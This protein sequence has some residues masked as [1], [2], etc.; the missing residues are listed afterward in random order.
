VLELGALA[1]ASGGLH[2]DGLADAADGL[3]PMLPRERRLEVMRSPTIGAFGAA[4]L[5]LV[6]LLEYAA[7]AGLSDPIRVVALIVAPVSARA[8]MVALLVLMPN[9]RP[10]GLGAVFKHDLGPLDLVVPVVFIAAVAAWLGAPSVPLVGA[11]LAAAL[12]VG[13]WASA[14]LGGCTGDVY[15][16]AGELATASV[17]VVAGL[18]RG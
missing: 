1:L 12:V 18:L 13:A 7:L 10:D 3:F 9:A 16:A 6:L 11:G 2:L 5:V 4:T 8:A 14:K 15:G 17:F